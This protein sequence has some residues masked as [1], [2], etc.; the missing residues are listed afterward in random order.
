MTHP[1]MEIYC[2]KGTELEGKRIVLGITGSIAATECF[3][4]TR[5]LIRYGATVIPVMTVGAQKLVTPDAMEFAS[6]IRPVT[7]LTGRTEHISLT[8][9]EDAADLFLI[10]PAT[11]NTISKIANGIDDTPVT[12]VATVVLG[13]N[14]PMAVAPAM[15]QAMFDNPAVKANI[16][17]L[18]SWGVTFI[19]PRTDG[20][21]AKVASVKET[22]EWVKR[23]LSSGDLMG[24]K[25]LVIGG[26]SEESMDSM[27]IITNRSSGQM[28]V[29]LVKSAFVRGA[30]A[31]LWMG[32]CNVDLPDH[33]PIR[34]FSSVSD[35]VL[36]LDGIDHDAVIVP[37]A[38]AD[39]TPESVFDGKI[40]SE[41]GMS[42][43][44]KP[45]QKV[46]PLISKKCGT[47]IG[48]KAES[49]LSQQ[50]LVDRARSRISEYGLYAVVANDISVA[51]KESSDA[52]IVT[53]ESAEAVSGSKYDVSSA[54]L[55]R[56]ADRL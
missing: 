35:L 26:R 27:R 44:L 15:H 36:M 28:A 13:S 34:R 43:E 30:D 32:G 6:G 39:F 19:G 1:S 5:E 17:R 38:L 33:V 51:G 4:L 37:A 2:S 14:I 41:K 18:E 10:Y 21:R 8:S 16:E 55:D 53:A 23:L 22:V 50:E 11:A 20:G 24:K 56:I 40:S 42:M 7:E 52:V 29:S 46:L 49:G 47:V 54:V 3:A 25:I 31:E 9:G 45:V 12:S 48:F